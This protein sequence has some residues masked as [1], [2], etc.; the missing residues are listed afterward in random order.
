MFV[1]QRVTVCQDLLVEKRN[2]LC[3][4][5][6]CL[7]YWN[8]WMI[9]K[10][11]RAP[12]SNFKAPPTNFSC[13]GMRKFEFGIYRGRAELIG[14]SIDPQPPA[15]HR[16][17]EVVRFFFFYI[18]LSLSSTHPKLNCILYNLRSKCWLFGPWLWPCPG[19]YSLLARARSLY[20]FAGYLFEVQHRRW[21]ILSLLYSLSTSRRYRWFSLLL[22][23]KK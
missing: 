6:T 17:G 7:G 18:F 15:A 16:W 22:K 4:I 13:F 5:S 1:Q 8:T 20:I 11:M 23:N 21:I 10:S 19:T 2:V 12:Y 3:Y 14:T 9:P